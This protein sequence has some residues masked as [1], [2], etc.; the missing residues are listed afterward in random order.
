MCRKMSIDDE[1]RILMAEEHV[2]ELAWFAENN[3]ELDG[4]LVSIA[5]DVAWFITKIR[6][7]QKEVSVY[8]DEIDFLVNGASTG[9]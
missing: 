3:N 7:M 6:K 1:Q 9:L 5:D 2:G 8:R 4:T